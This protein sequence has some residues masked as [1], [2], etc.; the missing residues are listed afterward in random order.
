MF[1]DFPQG[2]DADRAAMPVGL[3]VI[4]RTNPDHAGP[5]ADRRNARV[6]VLI[7]RRPEGSACAG[8]WEFPGGKAH[9]GE[10]VVACAVREASEELGVLVEP[11]LNLPDTCHRYAHAHVRL[12]P[13]VCRL[14]TGSPAPRDLAVAEHRWAEIETLDDAD[15]PEGNRP[16]LRALRGL[17]GEGSLA[18]LLQGI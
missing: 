7:S 15:F 11:L 3:A 2:A 6:E 5:S 18:R 13:V 1:T 10:D 8:F 9:A 4:L 14:R 16:I 12:H 17:D